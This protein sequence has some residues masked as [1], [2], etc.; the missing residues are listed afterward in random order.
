M[1]AESKP[2][3]REKRPYQPAHIG[4]ARN[5]LRPLT[6]PNHVFSAGTVTPANSANTCQS[7]RIKIGWGA[8][9]FWKEQTG[10]PAPLTKA[11]P[12]R[13]QQGTPGLFRLPFRF[14]GPASPNLVGGNS[15]ER[16]PP[17]VIR[18]SSR[19]HILGIAFDCR[20]ARPRARP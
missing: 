20:V 19:P 12:A 15:D 14:Y 9:R 18:G 13:S 1:S 10:A 16:R 8:R 5:T 4:R 6:G 11:S 3:P 2:S 17:S 7:T